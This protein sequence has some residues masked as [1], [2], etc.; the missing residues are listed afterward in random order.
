MKDIII[1]L[2]LSRNKI[3]DFSKLSATQT[4]S[5]FLEDENFSEAG[6]SGNLYLTATNEVLLIWEVP[7][8]VVENNI[9][10]ATGKIK[11]LCLFL[12][13]DHFVELA[14]AHLFPDGKFGYK[15]K[16]EVPSSIVKYFNQRFLDFKQTFAAGPDYIFFYKINFWTIPPKIF[17]KC[18]SAKNKML[19]I[20]ST[21]R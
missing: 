17:N 19:R 5:G 20:N 8:L 7:H 4:I 14:F 9:I 6:D 21:L 2:R 12:S 16:R 11:P 18:R 15:V 3:L 10:L 13:D 1:S